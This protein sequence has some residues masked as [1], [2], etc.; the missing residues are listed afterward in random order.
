MSRVILTL[1]AFVALLFG[2][3]SLAAAAGGS[4]G[5]VYTLTN[6]AANAVIAYDRSASGELT[7]SGTFPTGGSGGSLGSQG[8]VTISEDG[9]WLYAVDAGSNDVDVFRIPKSGLTWSDRVASGRLQPVSVTTSHDLG[10]E[11]HA[12]TSTI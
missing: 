2:P 6:T 12:T 8:A 3:A 1:V 7:W 9:R 10:D 11:V 4:A 5:A